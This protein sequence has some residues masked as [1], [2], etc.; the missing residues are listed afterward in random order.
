MKELKEEEFKDLKDRNSDS[1]I[2]DANDC[3][4]ETDKIRLPDTM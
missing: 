2:E 3:V 1:F 4:F